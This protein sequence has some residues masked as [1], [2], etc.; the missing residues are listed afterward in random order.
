[1]G[2]TEDEIVGW[3]SQL[4]GHEFEQ[5]LG[6]SEGQGRLA[7]CS[8]CG[9]RVRHDLATEQQQISQCLHL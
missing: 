7:C 8:P 3:H 2:M 4:D 5:T 6:D 1:M 9:R